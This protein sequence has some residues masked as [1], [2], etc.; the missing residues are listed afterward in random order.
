MKIMKFSFALLSLFVFLG[1][2]LLGFLGMACGGGGYCLA[3]LARGTA[4]PHE[5]LLAA[6]NFH[7]NVLKDF[8]TATS[9]LF[10]LTLMFLLLSAFFARIFLRTQKLFVPALFAFSNASSFDASSFLGE[11]KFISW[12]SLHEQSPS[13]A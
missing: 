8:S 10:P 11:Q 4:C 2:V 12:I 5:D 6:F 9:V 1:M 13:F 3:E 7:A